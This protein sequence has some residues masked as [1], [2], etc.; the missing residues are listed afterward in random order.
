MVATWRPRA[1]LS[2]TWRRNWYAD[3]LLT[4]KVE[5]SRGSDA[6]SLFLKH[7]RKGD[8]DQSIRIYELLLSR[9]PEV[10]ICVWSWGID[11]P[12]SANENGFCAG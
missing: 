10:R 11:Y 8:Y 9:G 7:F 5:G 2:C 3:R 6:V 1:R 12:T 4:R